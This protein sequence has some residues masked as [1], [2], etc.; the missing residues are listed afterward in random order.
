MTITFDQGYGAERRVQM[1]PNSRFW[2][3]SAGKQ[4]TSAA[5]L[6]L[7]ERGRLNLDDHISRFFPDAPVDKRVITIRELLSHT[8]GFGQSYVSEGVTDRAVAVRRMLAETLIDLPGHKFHYSNTN[9]QLAVAIVEITS[10]K[11]YRDFVETELFKP[12]GLHDT[13]F[14]GSPGAKAVVPAKGETPPRLLMPTWGG[15]GVYSTAHDLLTWY[16]A[17]QNEVVLSQA[18]VQTLIKPIAPIQE[19]QTALGWFTGKTPRGAKRI[20]TRGNDDF[21][22]NSLLYAYPGSDIVIVVLSHAG[23]ETN[24]MSWSRAVHGELENILGL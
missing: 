24:N 5:I 16:R 6:K 1:R 3:A 14:A 11:N 19:G 9:Y 23:N 20:F 8:S 10:D 12:A 2:I 18:S 22:P 21:G 4:F 17:L 7:A 13:G 15:E